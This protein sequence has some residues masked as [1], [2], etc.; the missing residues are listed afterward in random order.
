MEYRGDSCANCPTC[1]LSA[2][3]KT[4]SLQEHFEQE[5]IKKSVHVDLEQ[6]RVWV[7]LPF[8]KD[9]VEFLTKKHGAHDNYVQALRVYH[10]QC[11]KRDEVKDQVKKA[12][13]EL[14]DRGYM[15][16]ITDLPEDTQ[17]LIKSAPFNHYYPW[18]SV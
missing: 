7:D 17:M 15:V 5:V 1:K 8:I 10:A 9:P 11:S 6:E 16:K 12:H 4:K 3:A 2:R 14:V 18:R 13:A